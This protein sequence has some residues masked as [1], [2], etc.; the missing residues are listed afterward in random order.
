MS[1]SY[2]IREG[3]G[4]GEMEK[5]E[6]REGGERRGRVMSGGGGVEEESEREGIHTCIYV[7]LPC[8][9]YACI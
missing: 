4:N 8:K 5:Q 3:E 6:E 7:H 2:S 9:H 1:H